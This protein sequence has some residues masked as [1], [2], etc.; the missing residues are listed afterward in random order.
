MSEHRDLLECGIVE[1]DCDKF[2]WKAGH[3]HGEALGAEA[4]GE[5]ARLV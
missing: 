3:I 4:A 2:V 5:P 1:G